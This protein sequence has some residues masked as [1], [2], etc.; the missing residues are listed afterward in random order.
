MSESP[1]QRVGRIGEDLADVF[2]VRNGYRIIE[3][4]YRNRLGEID[5]VAEKEGIIHF[6]EVK[7]VSRET[8]PD[9]SFQIN[10]FEPEDNVHFKKR[11]RFKR[12]IEMYLDDR[13]V[14]CETWYQ[15][16]VIAVYIDNLGVRSKI[17]ML[18]DIDFT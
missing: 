3:R 5:I 7:T 11:K 9:G 6:V 1:K 12:A 18:E 4:N 8:L 2:L 16:D 14:T 15:A 13:N 17:E 10:D